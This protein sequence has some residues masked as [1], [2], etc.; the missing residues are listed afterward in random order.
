[1]DNQLAKRQ[2]TYTIPNSN[3]SNERKRE[4]E[5]KKT[6]KYQNHAKFN[7]QQQ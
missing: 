3:D 5:N 7:E 1:M 6:T 2:N 4:R